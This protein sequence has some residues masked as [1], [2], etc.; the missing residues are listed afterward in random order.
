MERFG[1]FHL[2]RRMLCSV[3]GLSISSH[4]PSHDF[5]IIFWTAKSTLTRL[6]FRHFVHI[7]PFPKTTHS[8]SLWSSHSALIPI[9]HLRLLHPPLI[10]LPSIPFPRRHLRRRLQLH[11]FGLHLLPQNA[12]LTV[13]SVEPAD[14]EKADEEEQKEEDPEYDCEHG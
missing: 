12:L 9:S 7:P 11:P 8:H 1:R 13:H 14:E 10:N 3:Q 6:A 5:E 4:R 2:E